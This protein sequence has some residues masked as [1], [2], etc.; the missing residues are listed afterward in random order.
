MRLK[1][2]Y[3]IVIIL[4]SA[5]LAGL[6][7]TQIIRGHEYY[8]LSK[9][10]SVRVVPLEGRRGR[11]LDRNGLAVADNRVSF[12]VLVSPQ[13]IQDQGR[14]F[15]YLSQTLQ[16][17]SEKLL[18]VYQKEKTASFIPVVLIEDVERDA[19]IVLE[20]NRFRFPGLLIRANSRRYYPYPHAN[21]HL[22]GYVGKINRSK[23]TQMKDYG[24]TA[25]DITGYSG[26]EEYYDKYLRSEAGGLQV[27]VNSRGQQVRV[28]GLKESEKGQDIRLTIDNRIQTKARQLLE[29]KS[30]AVVVMDVDT[31]E[32]LG[33]VSSPSFD[34][35]D[36]VRGQL[37][38]GIVTLLNDPSAP[39]LNRAIS[40]RYPPG[41]VFKIA[42]AV[43]A[44]E[45][46]KINPQTTFICPG[47]Y[48]L[49]ERSFSC[50]HTHGPQNLIEAIMQS[51][52]VYF[53]H[54]GLLAG[55]DL[56]A[57]YARLLGLGGLLHIDLP[58]EARG[59]IPDR[60]QRKDSRNSGWYSG[61]TLNLSIGQGE[62]LTTPIQ[63]ASL[64]ATIASNGRRVEPHLIK[65][66]ASTTVIYKPLPALP[67]R[68]K[69]FDAIKAG[70]K[71]AVDDERGTAHLLAAD[72][73]TVFGK[74]GTAQTSGGQSPH[75][76][77]AGYCPAPK[78]NIAICVFLAYGGSSYNACLITR[79]L[80]LHMQEEKIL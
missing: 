38:S 48:L 62:V 73:L 8:L 37:S 5:I 65:S 20:E 45:A 57:K 44:L 47:F 7:Y 50:S 27:E 36:F 40:G 42:V 79:D 16:I 56:I 54:A 69:T 35:N 22:L 30:G 9:N 58:S 26:I 60:T 2:F 59:F 55:A 78:S 70:L 4:F 23:I 63:L 74:T 52:N 75:A 24:Y 67:I 53:F 72:D 3:I 21:A 49:G 31:G 33:M 15:N 18:K 66:I 32:I 71:A 76:W 51:C 25:E 46:N 61:D 19:A 1:I 68:K 64:M 17:R 29:G 34:P 80:L 14:L 77:F 10:N 13:E 28:L 6:A 39:L 41:S 12:D 43:A 11:I